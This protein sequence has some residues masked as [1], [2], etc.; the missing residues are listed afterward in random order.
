M[1]N[2]RPGFTLVELLVVIGII[3]VLIG[4][5]LPALAGARR[6]AQAVKCAAELREIGHAVLMY[7]QDSKGYAPPARVTSA[8]NL[9]GV[10]YTALNNNT[11]YWMNF[12]AKYVTKTKVGFAAGPTN[13]PAF[14]SDAAEARKSIFWG[15]PAW[16]GYTIASTF[17][18]G[19]LAVAQ[20][21]YGFN[22]FPE[23][24]PSFPDR[25][26]KLNDNPPLSNTKIAVVNLIPGNPSPGTWYKFVKYTKPTERVLVADA[27]FWLVQTE[28]PIDDAGTLYGC[29]VLSNSGPVT[30]SGAT[31]CDWY[32]HGKYGS[33]TPDNFFNATSGKPSYN[34]LFCDGH[35]GNTAKRADIFLWQRM[36]FPG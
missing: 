22:P 2:R 30:T 6:Q 34:V 36:R 23:Y 31:T 33:R 11:P 26:V 8:Y 14:A 27:L 10:A 4:V 25:N 29:K 17:N 12:L 1:Q 19:D 18:P 5:L 13:N 15:C 24:S 28:H 21:G 3:A 7:V 32:R 35:V 16:S 20:T 9:D